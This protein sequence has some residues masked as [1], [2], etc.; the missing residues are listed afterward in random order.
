MPVCTCQDPVR[1]VSCMSTYVL[2]SN[3]IKYVVVIS[4]RSDGRI[5]V[6]SST[7]R[8]TVH[9]TV[10]HG[11]AMLARLLAEGPLLFSQG[12]YRKIE[13]KSKFV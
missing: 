9:V 10:I 1:A 4:S 2:C 13:L 5:L 8:S 3:R 6:G 11:S 12:Q 7:G